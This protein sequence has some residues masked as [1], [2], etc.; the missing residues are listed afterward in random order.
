MDCEA[1]VHILAHCMSTSIKRLLDEE[2]QDRSQCCYLAK[3]GV[4]SIDGGLDNW[5]QKLKTSVNISK[6]KTD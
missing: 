2:L 4:H 6:Q 5:K 1:H 3:A